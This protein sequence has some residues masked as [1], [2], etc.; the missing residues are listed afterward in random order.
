MFY[1]NIATNINKPQTN[2]SLELDDV[3]NKK[4]IL[5]TQSED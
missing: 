5:F 3:I 2:I 1:C 4:K